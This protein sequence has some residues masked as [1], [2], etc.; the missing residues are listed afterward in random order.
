MTSPKDRVINIK[1]RCDLN[2]EDNETDPEIMIWTTAEEPPKSWYQVIK[3]EPNKWYN[4]LAHVSNQKAW[5]SDAAIMFQL[6][7]RLKL[8]QGS[9]EEREAEEGGSSVPCGLPEYQK[10]GSA[11]IYF[12]SIMDFA[13]SNSNRN[14]PRSPLT[15]QSCLTEA[16][17]LVQKGYIEAYC[18]DIVNNTTLQPPTNLDIIPE[19]YQAISA[20]IKSYIDRLMANY[21]KYPLTMPE[22]YNIH[23]PLFLNATK[24]ILPG[25]VF[26]DNR[27]M[28][29]ST[30]YEKVLKRLIDISIK[31]DN[32]SYKSM[33]KVIN[34]ALSYK[35]GGDPPNS[36][37]II[38]LDIGIRRALQVIGRALSMISNAMAY[39]LDMADIPKKIISKRKLQSLKVTSGGMIE[40]VEMV[41]ESYD[42]P[43][44]KN[45]GDCEDFAAFEGTQLFKALRDSPDFT[46]PLLQACQELINL[47]VGMGSLGSVTS[48]SLA[49]ATQQESIIGTRYDKGIATGAHIT[50]IMIPKA[51]YCQALRNADSTIERRH[52]T[53]YIEDILPVLIS[54]GTGSLNPLPIG[55]AFYE[56]NNERK[57]AAAKKYFLRMN[58]IDM[59]LSNQEFNGCWVEKDSDYG[60]EY[61]FKRF[62]SFFRVQTDLFPIPEK[63]REMSYKFYSQTVDAP[64]VYKS[65]GTSKSKVIGLRQILAGTKTTN[66]D[67]KL[68]CELNNILMKSPSVAFIP[69]EIP[70]RDVWNNI[71]AVAKRLPPPDIPHI[72]SDENIRIIRSSYNEI[73]D[74]F[75]SIFKSKEMSQGS[76]ISHNIVELNLFWRLCTLNTAII[77]NVASKLDVIPV[78]VNAVIH[79]EHM[80]DII[81][82]VRVQVTLNLDNRYDPI[83]LDEFVNGYLFEP[84]EEAEAEQGR[85]KGHMKEMQTRD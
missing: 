46:D 48:N 72:P 73:K 49:G 16:T 66:Q 15:V 85:E 41:V 30:H 50:F 63:D 79:L 82:T 19:N 81:S 70:P 59:I 27:S 55:P 37:M 36:N 24:F 31:R 42:D 5:P 20:N 84:E 71:C 78:V 17:D 8:N 1:F 7:C 39:I 35:S 40:Y 26:W 58:A 22:V 65:D 80:I 69:M 54:E 68:G 60:R 28:H 2:L 14:F 25:F 64:F 57:I 75:E 74:K 11:S 45:D 23:A 47:Y 18:N 43:L 9:D 29:P 34:T 52:P 62:N 13:K 6:F 10:C 77:Q 51:F 21:K 3:I 56:R 38:K 53:Y 33:L 67:L 61:Q 4:T 44:I 76:S 12:S 32:W 83:K